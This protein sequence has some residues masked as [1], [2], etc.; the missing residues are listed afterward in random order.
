MTK[1]DQWAPS[2]LEWRQESAMERFYEL[3]GGDTTYGTLRFT[4][5]LGSL[6]EAESNGSK[7]TFKRNGFVSPQVT[8]RLAGSE[9]DIAT[10]VPKWTG[11]SGEIT[12]KSGGRL[13]FHS[14]GFWGRR[15]ALETEN[16]EPLLEFA[17]SGILRAETE[18]TVKDSCR[19]REDL[20]FLA[21]FCWYVLLLHMQD[22]A[23][24]ATS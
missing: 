22:T 19:Q 24:I 4:K 16:G 6:A 23:V 20:A 17:N 14:T 11:T 21:S 5:L 2:T 8:A 13:K 10:Y 9:D 3:K 1:L 12:L 15:W 18:L 7:W